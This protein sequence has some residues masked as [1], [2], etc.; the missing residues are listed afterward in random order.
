MLAIKAV[1]DGNKI[2]LPE[3]LVN[4]PPGEVIVIFESLATA[5]PDI[6]EWMELQ[7]EAF[8]RAWDNDEDSIYDSL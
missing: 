2:V 6:D 7:E 3:K 5:G 8:A 1:F 4:V